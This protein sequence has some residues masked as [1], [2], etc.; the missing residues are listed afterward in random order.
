M[1]SNKLVCQPWMTRICSSKECLLLLVSNDRDKVLNQTRCQN[2]KTG[3]ETGNRL[4]KHSASKSHIQVISMWVERQ[5]REKS[6]SS[7]DLA[8][9]RDLVSRNRYYL[10]SRAVEPGRE[11]K[12]F[13]MVGAGAKKIEWWSR[14]R[15]LN[16]EFLFNRHSFWNKPIVKIIQWFLFFNGPNRSS[17]G[18]KTFRGWSRC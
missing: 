9:S 7:V 15:S 8:L 4:N 16:F 2:W 5:A 11:L 1:F 14:S 18:A 10:S 12:Q 3:T 17:T 6:C 13:W